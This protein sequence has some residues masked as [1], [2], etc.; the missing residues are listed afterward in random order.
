MRLLPCSGIF[1]LPKSFKHI[2][3]FRS[4]RS[5]LQCRDKCR[6]E[7]I[8]GWFLSCSKNLPALSRKPPRCECQHN[9]LIHFSRHAELVSSCSS[10]QWNTST[11]RWTPRVSSWR[12]LLTLPSERCRLSV[13]QWKHQREKYWCHWMV[14][15]L[16]WFY[17][18]WCQPGYAHQFTECFSKSLSEHQEVYF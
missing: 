8:L 5:C 2:S 16:G 10:S 18:R 17:P 4:S 6:K 12:R 13:C 1:R 15:W 9:G 11:L 14:W 3:Y 7:R